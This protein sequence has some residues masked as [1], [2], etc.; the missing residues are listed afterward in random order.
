[1]KMRL[2]L[3]AAFHLQ[4]VHDRRQRREA[5]EGGKYHE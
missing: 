3:Y 5:A 1:M 2:R 4:A